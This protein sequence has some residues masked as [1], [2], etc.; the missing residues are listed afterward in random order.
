MRKVEDEMG[1]E[2]QT[3]IDRRERQK[4]RGQREMNDAR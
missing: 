3:A 2:I 1:A 4:G